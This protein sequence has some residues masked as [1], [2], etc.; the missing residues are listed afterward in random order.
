MKNKPKIKEGAKAI[1]MKDFDESYR[2][3]HHGGGD[4]GNDSGDE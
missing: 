3:K 4:S 2:N 1:I